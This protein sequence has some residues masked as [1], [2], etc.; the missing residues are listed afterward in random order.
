MTSLKRVGIELELT[1]D[2]VKRAHICAPYCQSHLHDLNSISV[3]AQSPSL[4][5]PA[6]SEYFRILL[7]TQ[8]NVNESPH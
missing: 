6:N 4:I 1:T 7:R 5:F 2:R 8:Q 3:H